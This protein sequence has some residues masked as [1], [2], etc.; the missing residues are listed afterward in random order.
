LIAFGIK[1]AINM[2]Y[3][4]SLLEVIQKSSNLLMGDWDWSFEV[5]RKSIPQP[6]RLAVEDR[7][8]T[9]FGYPLFAVSGQT[10]T[11]CFQG[12]GLCDAQI[13]ISEVKVRIART[14]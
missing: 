14:T 6:P 3:G 1:E 4:S 2:D 13:G 9:P 8:H 7:F 11:L 12:S 5:G 10:T